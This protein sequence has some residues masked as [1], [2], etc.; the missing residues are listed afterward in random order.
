MTDVPMNTVPPQTLA[1]VRYA[2]TSSGAL[3]AVTRVIPGKPDRAAD[4][5]AREPDLPHGLL[6]RIATAH[7][8]E[9]YEILL[10]SGRPVTHSVTGTGAA[11]KSVDSFDDG[12]RAMN[13]ISTLMFDAADL[14][15]DGRADCI[16]GFCVAMETP[17]IGG[18]VA[19]TDEH[20]TRGPWVR[21]DDA[22]N[23]TVDH[24]VMTPTG[25]RRAGDLAAGDLVV[26]DD[27]APRALR[28]M[29]A[30]STEERR[31]VNVRT[32]S[33]TCSAG[34]IR[35]ES[36]LDGRCPIESR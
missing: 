20:F 23:V 26:G 29:S 17:S 21:L 25:P 19:G 2:H 8:Y 32:R 34:G 4:P 9:R 30:S 16:C 15:T 28:S 5:T 18:D 10:V 24:R 31:G 7:A 22:V 6:S 13:D 27:G 14:A 35:F 36:E 11:R 12:C 33:G 1:S 3:A